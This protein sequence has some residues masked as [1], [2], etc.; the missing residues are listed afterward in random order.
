MVANVNTTRYSVCT[1]YMVFNNRCFYMNWTHYSDVTGIYPSNIEMKVAAYISLITIFFIGKTSIWRG[2]EKNQIILLTH[3]VIWCCG[4]FSQTNVWPSRFQTIFPFYFSILS[5][6]ET[7]GNSH[8]T[9][10][11]QYQ[12]TQRTEFFRNVPRKTLQH[13]ER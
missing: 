8:A 2:R 1:C 9:I 13:R 11:L 4:E 10:L 3:L 6:P 12:V 5:V 7:R